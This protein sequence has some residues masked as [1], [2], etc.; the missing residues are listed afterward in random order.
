MHYNLR[1]VVEPPESLRS[2]IFPFADRCLEEVRQTTKVDCKYRYTAEYFCRFLI[3][4]RSI[5]LQDAVAIVI[6]HGEH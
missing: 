4:L 5:I 3:D 1:T 6:A 2:M